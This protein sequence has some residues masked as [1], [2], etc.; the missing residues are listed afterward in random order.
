MKPGDGNHSDV[1]SASRMMHANVRTGLGPDAIAEALVDNLHYLQAKLPEHATRNDWYMALAYTVR[2]RLL[3]GYIKT[4]NARAGGH[5]E[6]EVGARRVGLSALH[7]H[8]V[9]LR[10]ASITSATGIGASARPRAT[11]GPAQAS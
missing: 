1:L 9:A 11:H 7:L 6:A 8:S 3:D 10:N 5:V 4:A 2:D